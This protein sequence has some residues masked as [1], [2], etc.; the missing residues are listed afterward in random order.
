VATGNALAC[1]RC[2]GALVP[3]EHVFGYF[4]QKCGWSLPMVQSVAAEDVRIERMS[5]GFPRKESRVRLTLSWSNT[6]LAE[7]PEEVWK[8]IQWARAAVLIGRDRPIAALAGLGA[9][10]VWWSSGV[11]WSTK[12]LDLSPDVVAVAAAGWSEW[13]IRRQEPLRR[14]AEEDARIAAAQKM[15]KEERRKARLAWADAKLSGDSARRQPIPRVLRYE[16]F[17]RD[18]GR[19]VECGSTFDLQ[20]DHVIPLAMGGATSV[21]NLQLL[22][23][24]CNR[25]KGATLG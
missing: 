1:P 7:I 15:A 9:N 3:V 17:T 2:N 25:R 24:D 14:R 18:R 16:V 19:C 10:D 5:A 12:D 21:D 11:F 22:C 13:E 4:C 6:P 23:S 20:F 8:S